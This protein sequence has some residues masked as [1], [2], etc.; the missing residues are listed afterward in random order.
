MHRNTQQNSYSISNLLDTVTTMWL[1]SDS[2]VTVDNCR[3]SG[4]CAAIGSEVTVLP[5]VDNGDYTVIV[6]S[7]V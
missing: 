4:D 5:A 7:T 1:D 6:Q 2:V 3:Q